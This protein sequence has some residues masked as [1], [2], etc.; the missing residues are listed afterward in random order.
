MKKFLLFFLC[1]GFILWFIWPVIIHFAEKMH[2]SIEISYM[3]STPSRIEEQQL[4]GTYVAFNALFTVITVIIALSTYLTAKKRELQQKIHE[5]EISTFSRFYDLYDDFEK[6]LQQLKYKE[7]L[8]VDVITYFYNKYR[9]KELTCL[10]KND[11]I[12]MKKN[13]ESFM[14][15]AKSAGIFIPAMKLFSIFNWL[16]SLDFYL[17]SIGE[18]SDISSIL[19]QVEVPLHVLE[20]LVDAQ[21]EFVFG[22][23]RHHY[24]SIDELDLKKY[25]GMFFADTVLKYERTIEKTLT[26]QKTFII[27][28][29]KERY[30][31]EETH[32]PEALRYLTH[33]DRC[34]TE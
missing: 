18:K 14:K 27:K 25:K 22:K 28:K 34:Q 3:G 17:K 29:I 9:I 5:L 4:T 16:R 13:D 32:I 10:S 15:E 8:G 12:A 23:Y 30:E 6:T 19:P 11:M 7:H 24:Y 26:L 21:V 1:I 31:S 2:T 20:K 33:F